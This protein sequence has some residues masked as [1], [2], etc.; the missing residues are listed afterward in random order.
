MIYITECTKCKESIS[1]LNNEETKIC[2]KCKE[3]IINPT[4]KKGIK[5]K[6]SKKE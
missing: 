4:Y 6:K 2:N 3:V 1:F 5:N